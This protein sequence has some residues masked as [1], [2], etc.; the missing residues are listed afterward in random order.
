MG[1]RCKPESLS[2]KIIGEFFILKLLLDKVVIRKVK[3]KELEDYNDL[4]LNVF[5]KTVAL[6]YTLNGIETF[7]NISTLENTKKRYHSGNIMLIA[8]YENCIIGSLELRDKNHI[9][10]FFVD[11][12]YH[13]NGIGTKL[14]LSLLKEIREINRITVNSSPY[15]LHFY[16]KLGFVQIGPEEKHE[17]GIVC[18]PLEFVI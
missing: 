2:A 16:M 6:D 11:T 8:Q 12:K 1:I 10:R 15:A 4:I 17:N 7:T 9:S 3:E 5:N 18:I 13:R 14:F